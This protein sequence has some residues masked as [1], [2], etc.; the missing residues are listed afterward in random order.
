VHAS[1]GARLPETVFVNEEVVSAREADVVSPRR[2]ILLVSSFPPSR[3][4]LNEYGYHLACSLR[5]DPRVDLVILAD[6]T[7]TDEEL[8]GFCIERCWR[9]D[10]ALNP[11]RLMAQIWKH[12]PDVV[13]F[14]IG[15]STFARKPV[16]AFLALPVP[17]LARL[18]GCYTHVTLHTIFER[19]DL[20]DAGVSWPGLYRAA[21]RV[22][23]HLLLLADDVSVL[24]PSFQTDLAQNY[25]KRAS[26]VKFRPHGTFEGAERVRILQRETAEKVILVFGYWGTYK[27]LE[28]LLE[29]MDEVVREVPDAVLAVAG[30][31]HPS[32]PGYLE[33][34]QEQWEGRV[35]VRFLGYV[36]ESELPTLFSS[37]SVLVL[38]YSSAAGTSGVMHQ[39]CQYGLPIVAAAIPEIKEIAE[40]E[41]VAAEFYSPGDGRTLAKHLIGLLTSEHLRRNFSQR[42]LLAAVATPMSQVVDEYLRFFEQRIAT[43]RLQVTKTMKIAEKQVK[44]T[45]IQSAGEW[46]LSS[47]IQEASGGVARYYFSDERER[48]APLTTEITGYA[49][50]ALVCLYKQRSET[51]YLDAAIKAAC[52]LV[53]A[54][55]R[56]CSAMPFE[57]DGDKR[58][59]YFFDNGIIVRGLLSVWREFKNEQ[60]L[61]TAIR[62]ADSMEHDFTDGKEFAPIL[63]LPS[64]EPIAREAGRWS[65]NPGCYQLKAAL[66]WYELWQI[67]NNESYRQYYRQMLESAL[68]THNSFLPGI[69][70][71]LGVMD[72]LHPYCYFLEGLLPVIDEDGPTKAMP[73]GIDR[74]AGYVRSIGPKFLRSDVLAQLLRV[75]LFADQEGVAPLDEKAAKEEVEMMRGFQSEDSDPRL[76]GGFWFGKKNGE[77]LPFMNPVSTAFCTQALEMWGRRTRASLQWETLI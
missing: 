77:M 7:N 59:S 70:D 12:K 9:F 5:D 14:N 32:T 52:Y 55:D 4:D 51:G 27:R 53:D 48:N 30:T 74:V 45:A 2:K 33:S 37:A 60:F 11:L 58:Y 6:E 18:S 36:P 15:F 72:R 61:R 64:K 66:G 8:P 20:K 38:P 54:W 31:N 44:T 73:V 23:T 26:R 34:L 63:E 71:E 50:S 76:G 56:N 17:A 42:N 65:R 24:L 46:F 43:P 3:G 25:G 75:R 35:P 47:G 29:W 49:A 1:C 40:Q 19:I 21:G 16:A 22:A 67:T 41:N 69:P 62:V 57:V 68:A 10:S 39:A 28:L 13:W